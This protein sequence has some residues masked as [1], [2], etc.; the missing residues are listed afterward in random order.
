MR[1]WCHL[2]ATNSNAATV[3]RGRENWDRDVKGKEGERERREG[4]RRGGGSATGEKGSWAS[5]KRG[6]AEDGVLSRVAADQGGWHT[7]PNTRRQPFRGS[8]KP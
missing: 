5:S 7:P 8:Q 4:E 2:V 1:H 3:L 6:D